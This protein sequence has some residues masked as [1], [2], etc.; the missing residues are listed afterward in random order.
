MDSKIVA[1]VDFKYVYTNKITE[2][3]APWPDWMRDKYTQAL[4]EKQPL[5]IDTSIPSVCFFDCLFCDFHL[6]YQG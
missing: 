2:K 5:R 4:Q 3:S 1:T 6:K